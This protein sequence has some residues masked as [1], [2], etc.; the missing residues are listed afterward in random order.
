M[1]QGGVWSRLLTCVLVHDYWHRYNGT[2]EHGGV[3]QVI[4]SSCIER[5]CDYN[6]GLPCET[7]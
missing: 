2:R 7:R 1:V 3:T 4:V 5:I 6:T